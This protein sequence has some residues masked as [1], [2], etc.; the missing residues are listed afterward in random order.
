MG[1]TPSPYE[2]ATVAVID[3]LEIDGFIEDH[4]DEIEKRV[5]DVERRVEE[6]KKEGKLEQGGN[7]IFVAECLPFVAGIVHV[8][9]NLD[10]F[11][12]ARKWVDAELPNADAVSVL[13]ALTFLYL[14]MEGKKK[15]EGDQEKVEKWEKIQC[16]VDSLLVP[17]KSPT[18]A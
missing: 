17:P 11:R 6:A 8:G 15:A 1:R 12:V 7:V 5:L 16:R 18:A 14:V 10:K 4:W 3:K 2:Q 13:S 9:S